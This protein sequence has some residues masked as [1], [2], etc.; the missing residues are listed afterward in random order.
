MSGRVAQNWND[1]S[2]CFSGTALLQPGCQSSDDIYNYTKGRF[3][4]L[5]LTFQLAN[6]WL[7]DNQGL[8]PACV[9]S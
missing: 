1:Q 5:G 3:H 2:Q 7:R 6:P 9:P 4:R 8:A